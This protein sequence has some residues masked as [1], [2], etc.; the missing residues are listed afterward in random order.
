MR[1]GEKD[2]KVWLCLFTCLI[3][4]AIYLVVIEDLRSTTFIAALKE[5]SARRSQPKMMLSDNATTFVHASKIL[6]YIASQAKVKQELTN[7]D[8]EW[9]WTPAKASWHGAIFERMIGIVKLE[10]AKMLGNGLF[11]LQD[12]RNH[13]ISVEILVNSR[14]LCRTSNEEIITPNHILNGSGAVQGVGLSDPLSEQVLEDILKARKQLPSIYGQIK[15][16]QDKFWEALQTQYLETLKF[17]K[18]RMGN[19]FLTKPKVGQ[20]CLVY[21][22]LPRLKWKLAI[23]L[24]LVQ[25]KDGDYRQA[26][27]KTENG[28]TT[29]SLNHLYSLEL[30]LE[31]L[32]DE[33]LVLQQ[34]SRAR[35]HE[36]PLKELKDKLKTTAKEQNL[37]QSDIDEIVGKLDQE[38]Q[39]SHHRPA[40]PR[41]E[42]AI[43]AAQLRK[44]MI[45]DNV[46]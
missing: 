41:R 24:Q 31:D 16:K 39:D 6:A 44:E 26:L 11:T 15:E 21:S 14:P 12:F 36:T 1:H 34:T 5:L 8:I 30:E 42:A 20:V 17:T 29:R 23:I 35:V 37:P 2:K 32:N 18:D 22:D 46:I 9:K 3:S 27:I 45:A 40:R 10:L 28:T 25:S 19:Q 4:R 43:K 33:H 7:L 13:I 38:L